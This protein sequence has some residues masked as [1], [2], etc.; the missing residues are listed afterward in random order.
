[1]ASQIITWGVD[2]DKAVQM[3]NSHF[4]RSFSIGSN[5][6]KIRV[7]TRI[8]GADPLVGSNLTGTPRLFIG[9]SHSTS[10]VFGDSVVEHAVGVIQTGATVTWGIP[11]YQ[12]SFTPCCKTGS[13]LT[14]F[15]SSGTT[16]LFA[17]ASVVSASSTRTLIFVDLE[18]NAPNTYLTCSLVYNGFATPLDFTQ[19]QFFYY[20]EQSG[21]P[22]AGNHNYTTLGYI[23]IDETGNG[24]LDSINISWDRTIPKII[25]NDIAIYK[26]A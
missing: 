19:T 8:S 14:T 13:L 23:P 4:A 10:S 18:R 7:A 3:I 21:N 11:Y 26:F 1:M 25:V 24:T 6:Q 16:I 2:N 15:G 9:L 17:T 12:M 22:G 5:W 20:G